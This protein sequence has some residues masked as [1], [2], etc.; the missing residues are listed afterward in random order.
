MASRL[1]IT[2]LVLSN[3]RIAVCHGLSRR[4][5]VVVFPASLT[6]L[7]S[8]QNIIRRLRLPTP[9]LFHKVQTVSW[10]TRMTSHC[11]WLCTFSEFCVLVLLCQMTAVWG[12]TFGG[13]CVPCTPIPDDSLLSMYL[14]GV[15]V[16]CTPIPDDSRLRM[17]LSGIY[18]PCTP[19]PGDSYTGDLDPCCRD[20]CR[21]CCVCRKL[22]TPLL[23][24]Y[25]YNMGLTDVPVCGFS[26]LTAT[27]L[28]KLSTRPA[29]PVVSVQYS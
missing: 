3:E 21:T 28:P 13:F 23:I 20:P 14:S 22:S 29:S 17:Y 25:I 12:C 9:W 10:L 1:P 6:D 8:T 2:S 15:Y 27:E 18:V 24:N 26:L 4:S 5:V 7:R 16:P 11:V 19:I